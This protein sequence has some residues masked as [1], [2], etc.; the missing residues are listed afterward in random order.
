[1]VS[2][3]LVDPVGGRVS[4]LHRNWLRI[5]G[6]R[7]GVRLAITRLAIA[8]CHTRLAM[9]RVQNVCLPTTCFSKTWLITVTKR[10]VPKKL[11][12]LAA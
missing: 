8:R 9:P 6:Q 11:K 2:F 7:T 1:M 4:G 12:R 10:R 5:S 3:G